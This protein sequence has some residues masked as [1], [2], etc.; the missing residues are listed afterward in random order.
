MSEFHVTMVT[1]NFV[2]MATFGDV[3]RS[4]TAFHLQNMSLVTFACFENSSV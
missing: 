1:E 2:H 4:K 3:W